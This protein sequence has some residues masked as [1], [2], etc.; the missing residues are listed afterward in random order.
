[1][2]VEQSQNVQKVKTKTETRNNSLKAHYYG[3]NNEQGESTTR[4][5]PEIQ[6]NIQKVNISYDQKNNILI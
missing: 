2:R 6:P 1:M 5:G 3:I 4:S